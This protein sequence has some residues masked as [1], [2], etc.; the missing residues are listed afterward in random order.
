MAIKIEGYGDRSFNAL[1]MRPIDGEKFIK[2]S[3]SLFGGIEL[4]MLAIH[5]NGEKNICVVKINMPPHLIYQIVDAL[6]E[7]ARMKKRDC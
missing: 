6:N 4:K 5:K 1:Q 2:K 3:A 7:D